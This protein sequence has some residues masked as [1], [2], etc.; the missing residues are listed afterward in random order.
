MEEP[1]RSGSERPEGPERRK[2]PRYIVDLAVR[3]TGTFGAFTGR[4]CDICRD[5]VWIESEKDVAPDVDVVL[6]IEFPGERF[7]DVGGRVIRTGPG[8][9]QPH[10][11]AV[12]F[13]SVS[14]ATTTAID[15][16]IASQSDPD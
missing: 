4:V 1:S 5:A 8:E 7:S 3:V 10:G 6:S 14:P 13:T 15:F 11:M 16:F 9:R 12:L 2:Y